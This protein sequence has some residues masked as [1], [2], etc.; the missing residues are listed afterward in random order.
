MTIRKK[1]RS[2]SNTEVRKVFKLLLHS[3]LIWMGK[4]K[5]ARFL[6]IEGGYHKISKMLVFTRQVQLP[7]K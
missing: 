6:L 3:I 2:T 5:H 4:E 1:S 7:V